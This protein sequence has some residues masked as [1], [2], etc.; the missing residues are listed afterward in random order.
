MKQL[1]TI[2]KDGVVT[3][4][5]MKRGKGL[6]LRTLGVAKIER[7]SLIEWSDLYQKWYI[8]FLNGKMANR[9]A[10]VSIADDAGMAD[11]VGESAIAFHFELETVAERSAYLFDD[12]EDAVIAEVKLIQALRIKHGVHYV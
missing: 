6:D 11:K 5:Q 10:C 8:K 7:S 4:L 9:V 12:Y 1:I 3:G 2:D